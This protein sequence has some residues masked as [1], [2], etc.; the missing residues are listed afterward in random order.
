MSAIIPPHD[1]IQVT[2]DN[3][4]GQC[5]ISMSRPLPFPMVAMILGKMIGQ[6]GEDAG[7]VPAPSK[8]AAAQDLN[9][10]RV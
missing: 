9:G 10:R 2:I 4:S 6:L 5:Q 3:T 7:R 8:P 1:F